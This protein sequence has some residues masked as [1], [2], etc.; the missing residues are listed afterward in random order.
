MLAICEKQR[1]QK[2]P[3]FLADVMQ[4]NIAEEVTVQGKRWGWNTSVVAGR[5]KKNR[6]SLPLDDAGDKARQV[7]RT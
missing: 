3:N 5:A 6:Y 1:S 2:S 4:Q 7:Y